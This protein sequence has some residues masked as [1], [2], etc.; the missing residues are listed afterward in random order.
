LAKSWPTRRQFLGSAL[1]GVTAMG[2][3]AS[4]AGRANAQTGEITA[5]PVTDSLTLF[6]GAGGN[7]LV[8]EA[9]DALLMIDSGAEETAAALMRM[10]A[11]RFGARPVRTLINTNWRLDHTGGNA[12]AAGQGAEILAQ[13]N[14]RGWMG[15]E[16]YV[17]WEDRHYPAREPAARPTRSFDRSG[18]MTFG[19]GAVRY[20]HLPRAHTDGDLYVH[21]PEQDVIAVGNVVSAG[22][23]PILDYSTGGWSG[24]MIDSLA[25]LLEMSGAETVFVAGAGPTLRR[26]DVQ[27]QHDMM[28]EVQ[29]R[30]VQAMRQGKGP[31]E[32]IEDGLTSDFG[33]V[34]GDPTLYLY[35]AYQGIYGHF[36]DMRFA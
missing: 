18:E 11:D 31:A 33:A 28:T 20:G 10:V 5:A 21:F 1:A 13:E 12:V 7:V 34:W 32:M 22:R 30:M 8:A 17:A 23:Y 19:A 25:M 4:A 26:E 6:S 15:M 35:N 2:V 29:A 36:R 24:E 9:P 14:T 27:A 16:F 3:S